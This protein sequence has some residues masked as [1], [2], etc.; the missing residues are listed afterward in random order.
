[1]GEVSEKSYDTGPAIIE[2]T[3][4]MGDKN[5]EREQELTMQLQELEKQREE[6]EAN[7]KTIWQREDN[8]EMEMMRADR[9]LDRMESE[10][11]PGDKVMRQLLEEKQQMM[12]DMKNKRA[13][14]IERQED[15]LRKKKQRIDM[16]A[17]VVYM[18]LASI[19]SRKDE[20][21]SIDKK[22]EEGVE[23]DDRK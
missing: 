17:E 3:N 12:R 11:S 18:E 23:S 16:E 2:V 13:E 8:R 22:E 1:M 7:T 5:T 9:M 21:G 6:L 14:F 15:E 19:Q 10:C 20:K 4:E